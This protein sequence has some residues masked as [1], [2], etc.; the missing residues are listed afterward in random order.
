MGKKLKILVTNDDGIDSPGLKELVKA[1]K[2][3]AD[4]FVIA[5]D[6]QQS[7]ISHAMTIALP[8]VPHKLNINGDTMAYAVNGTPVDC[9]KLGVSALMS[10]KPDLICSGINL[11]PN[12]SISVKYSGTVAAAI[13]GNIQ[14]IPSIA[15]SLNSFSYMQDFKS[16]ANYAYKIVNMLLSEE[17]P[18]NLLLNVNIPSLN[19]NEIKGIKITQLSNSKWIDA[20][21][22]RTDPFGRDYYWFDGNYINLDND[23]DSDD[24]AIKNGF[25]SITPI[26]INYNHSKH[27]GFLKKVLT[28]K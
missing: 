10:E 25:V 6:R 24:N 12:T 21:Q 3:L 7:A 26:E 9:V 1:L 22:K 14:G 18:K 15:F 20:Y 2:G 16:A 28:T 5:P 13:E 19:E 17:L 11:G 8:L 27:L 4:I 23:S